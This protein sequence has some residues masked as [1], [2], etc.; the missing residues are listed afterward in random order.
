MRPKYIHTRIQYQANQKRGP[1][2]N[3]EYGS[4]KKFFIFGTFHWFYLSRESSLATTWSER[5][6]GA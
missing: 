1:T 6:A 3:K 4:V 2:M 5:Q